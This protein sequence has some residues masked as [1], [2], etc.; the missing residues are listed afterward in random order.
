MMWWLWRVESASSRR[1]AEGGLWACCSNRSFDGPHLRIALS[2]RHQRL[3]VG[4]AILYKLCEAEWWKDC[5]KDGEG[6]EIQE[7]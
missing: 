5:Y 2:I 1:L 3:R 4:A 6:G 7:G